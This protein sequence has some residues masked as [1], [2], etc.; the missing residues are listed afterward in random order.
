MK[1][2]PLFL[3]S[4]ALLLIQGASAQTK[5]DDRI[6]TRQAAFTVIAANVGKI[7]TNLDGEYKKQDVLD[8]ATVIQSLAHTNVASWFPAGTN[9]GNG[10]HETQVKGAWFEAENAKKAADASN[11]FKDEADQLAIVAALGD[12]DAVQAQFGKLRGTCK[13]CHDNF[14]VD[15][16]QTAAAPAPAAN[17]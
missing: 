10:F 9:T 7:K 14:R 8:A 2:Q 11:K 6:K 15:S 5:P 17:K 13:G 1:W 3:G 16:T 4:L 12:K